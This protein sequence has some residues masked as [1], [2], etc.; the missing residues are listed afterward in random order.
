MG[1]S[2]AQDTKYAF[3]SLK[4]AYPLTSST[5]HFKQGLML[6]VQ[7]FTFDT[8]FSATGLYPGSTLQC[9]FIISLQ[10]LRVPSTPLFICA[11]MTYWQFGG[12]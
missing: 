2:V 7:A 6:G 9:H 1:A 4:R 11:L 8:V 10:A 5:G 3:L 12:R